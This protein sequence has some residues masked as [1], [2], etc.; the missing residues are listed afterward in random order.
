MENSDGDSLHDGVHRPMMT[1]RGKNYDIHTGHIASYRKASFPGIG[2]VVSNL[3]VVHMYF[4]LAVDTRDV[5]E[6]VK[7]TCLQAKKTVE[8]SFNKFSLKYRET[9]PDRVSVL[10]SFIPC[11]RW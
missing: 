1:R 5:R 3:K 6:S 4:N 9:H 7:E 8:D 11:L 2:F 10:S